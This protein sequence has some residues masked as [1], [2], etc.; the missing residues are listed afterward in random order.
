ML[1][2]VYG[3]SCFGLEERV[4]ISVI[5]SDLY[6]D[7][8]TMRHFCRYSVWPCNPFNVEHPVMLK[9][10]ELWEKEGYHHSL[11][12]DAVLAQY[13]CGYICALL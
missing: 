3:S 1:I 13:T 11:Y 12:H 6:N 2:Y 8:V 10:S 9:V 7:C 4:S 5:S